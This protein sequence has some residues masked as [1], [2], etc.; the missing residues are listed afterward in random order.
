[1]KSL[2]LYC[3]LSFAFYGTGTAYAQIP[4]RESVRVV[5]GAMTSF[6]E[7][8]PIEKAY[9]Q[10]DKPWYV[11]GDT[12]WF[13]TYLFNAKDLT[14]ATRSGLLYTEVANDSNKV[15]KREMIPLLYGLGRA[16]IAIDKTFPAG[17]YT[18]RVYT[19][20]MRNFGEDFIPVA[21]FEVSELNE[22]DWMVNARIRVEK[23]SSGDS[24]RL[25]LRFADLNKEPV[26]LREMRLSVLA[27]KKTLYKEDLETK[28]DGSLEVTL[29]LGQ[30]SIADNLSV[31]VEDR[32]NGQG[33]RKLSFPVTPE[34]LENIDLQFLPEGGN[35]V[36][37]LETTV[38]FKAI[39]EDGKGRNISGTVLN[40]KLQEV[41]AFKSGHL[42]MGA[43]PLDPFPGET[44]TAKVVLP[45]G[46][47]KTYP[48]PAVKNTGTVLRVADIAGSDS[49][50]VTVAFSEDLVQAA[51]MYYLV[52]QTRGVPCYGASFNASKGTATMKLSKKLF[53]T[54]IV[55]FTLL[56]ET[57]T[58][59][60]ERIVF[61]NHHDQL[62][63]AIYAK[64][65]YQVRDSIALRVQVTGETGE[66]VRG[67]F[68]LAVTDDSQVKR[69]STKETSLLASMLLTSD[70]KGAVEDPGY[71]FTAGA[72][73]SRDIDHLMLTQ[74]WVGYSW[75]QVF[76]KP[77]A[78]PFEAEKS[79]T[80]RGRVTNIMNK[81]VA[82]SGLVLL[83]KKPTA[84]LDTVTNEQG[85]F[86]FRNLPVSD[87]TA[88]F[89]QARNKKGKSFNVGI[90]VNEFVPPMFTQP[91]E[92][93]APWYL[94][95][96][97][98]RLNF[99]THKVQEKKEDA[100][101]YGGILMNEV[102]IRTKRVITGSKNLNGPGE[103]D[104][105]LDEEFM[106][107]SGRKTLGDLLKENVKGF[108]L[109]GFKGGRWFYMVNDM[110]VHLIIDGTNVDFT[111]MEGTSYREHLET[112][113]SYYSADDIKGIEVMRTGK[114][115]MSYNTRFLPPL[116]IPWEHCF[117]EVTT[118]TGHG[119]FMKKTTGTYVFRPL[120]L[121]VPATFYSPRYDVKTTLAAGSDRR[122]T[123]FWAPDIVT[124]KD[125]MA[126][127]S[128]FAADLPGTYTVI[129][130]GS[131]MQGALGSARKVL[132][133]EKK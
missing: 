24:A 17:S 116:S 82:N 76:G 85:I 127:V 66:P 44:Y 6:A 79:F 75:L 55:R 13:K 20:W 38:G 115:Q 128:F 9:V 26:A 93:I 80:V 31:L 57:K 95:T 61:V 72:G 48:L 121:S 2:R 52:A 98:L 71:Y 54:G 7:S 81:P 106:V 50:E 100:K 18:L 42:G 113:F 35:L 25:A 70:L 73:V 62:R 74:G 21:R 69:D 14:G 123:I 99:I 91:Q 88:F 67:T 43:F 125:G 39:G 23:K 60:N 124:D 8:H 86:T 1:M 97:P 29:P 92:R 96:D 101:K 68:S 83:S 58:P 40:S 51:A 3:L 78:P 133:V 90:E 118:R 112:F 65:Q 105:I 33:K 49:L 107:K 32:R 47:V 64:P 15:I 10:L 117:I 109:K 56:N 111:R 114:Y 84:I 94:N 16:N 89:L 11:Q 22:K 45:G 34:N 129:V 132:A 120:P 103:A 108:A 37:H 122:S 53:A 87:S 77:S 110:L 102:A 63:L 131:D 27:G 46:A 12:L 28:L 5:L 36:G 30:R 41:G 59:L 130:E 119:P 19:N 104:L 4:T 126:T